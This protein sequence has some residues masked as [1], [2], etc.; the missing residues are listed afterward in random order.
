MQSQCTDADEANEGELT[1]ASQAS[2]LWRKFASALASLCF[3][4]LV[5]YV[6]VVLI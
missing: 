2:K 3:F 4:F 5:S 6:A 1:T